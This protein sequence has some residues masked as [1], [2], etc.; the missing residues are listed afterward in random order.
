MSSEISDG[1]VNVRTGAR[2]QLGNAEL[3]NAAERQLAE[4]LRRTVTRRSRAFVAPET[5]IDMRMKPRGAV[6]LNS[7]A[8]WTRARS[9]WGAKRG[10]RLLSPTLDLLCSMPRFR[11]RLMTTPRTVDRGFLVAS[12]VAPIYIHDFERK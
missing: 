2:E 3:A 5:R 8:S 12:F 9:I 1:D 7:R 11:W 4:R 6:A 10:Y